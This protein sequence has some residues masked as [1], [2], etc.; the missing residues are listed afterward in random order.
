MKKAEKISE[1]Q[2]KG[3]KPTLSNS[4]NIF[5]FFESFGPRNS[6]IA[7]FLISKA[8]K[9]KKATKRLKITNFSCGKVLGPKMV[10][11]GPKQSHKVI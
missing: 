7:V 10:S 5:G 9:A 4:D 8:I 3:H 11:H 6:A 2:I 1:G